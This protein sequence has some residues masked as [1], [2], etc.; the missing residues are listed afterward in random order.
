MAAKKRAQGTNE[1]KRNTTTEP[2]ADTSQL[3]PY[4]NRTCLKIGYHGL[5]VEVTARSENTITFK[6]LGVAPPPDPGAKPRAKPKAKSETEYSINLDDGTLAWGSL[7]STAQRVDVESSQRV[8]YLFVS[9]AWLDE[10]PQA[11]GP[12]AEPPKWPRNFSL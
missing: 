4:W 7:P 3:L 2:V 6:V 12:K 1:D 8:G 9:Q 10:H 11:C 5:I